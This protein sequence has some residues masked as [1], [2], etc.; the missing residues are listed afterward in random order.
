MMETNPI[1]DILVEFDKNMREFGGVGHEEFKDKKEIYDKA[2][3]RLR[4]LKGLE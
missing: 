2:V 3:L 1:I 4:T